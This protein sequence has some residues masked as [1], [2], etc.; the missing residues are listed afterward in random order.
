MYFYKE[1]ETVATFEECSKAYYELNNNGNKE[2]CNEKNK[3]DFKYQYPVINIDNEEIK[4][5]NEKFK[6]NANNYEKQFINSLAPNN[7]C[8][9]ECEYFLV[10]TAK[11]ELKYLTEYSE[12]KY[13]IQTGKYLTVILGLYERVLS[14]GSYE[15]FEDAYVIDSEKG[16]L[17]SK[18]DILSIYN[19]EEQNILNEISK[20][21]NEIE[22]EF[23]KE[24]ADQI[25]YN[26]KNNNYEVFINKNE[27]LVIRAEC[28]VPG[29]ELFIYNG[30]NWQ[31]K[32]V[33]SIAEI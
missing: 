32:S 17:L 22:Y 8:T 31:I 5:L 11:G 28:D 30:I 4:K 2:V 3:K 10:K 9:E 21:K 24:Y 18:K 20:I 16:K 1:V 25:L 27:E 26:I 23:E 14:G 33:D 6:E 29:E 19:F 15:N 7:P 12:P 13:N